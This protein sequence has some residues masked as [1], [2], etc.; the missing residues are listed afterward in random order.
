MLD[1]ALSCAAAYDYGHA[2]RVIMGEYEDIAQIP[3]SGAQGY[4]DF[5]GTAYGGEDISPVSHHNWED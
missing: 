5:G 1:V 2:E 3:Y 4:L